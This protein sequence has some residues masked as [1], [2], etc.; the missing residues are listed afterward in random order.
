LS[1]LTR[2]AIAILVLFAVVYLYGLTRTGMLGPD[3]PR[4]AAIGLE[5]A[6]SGDWVTPRLWG[7]GWFEKPPLLYWMTAAA[8]DA[9]LGP[10]L[11]PR[12]PVALC[13]LAFLIFFYLAVRREFGPLEALYSTAILGTT[14]AWLTYNSVAVPDAPMS[15]LFCAALLLSLRWTRP[16]EPGGVGLPVCQPTRSDLVIAL[17]AG[18]LLG[19]AVL[20][21]S[22]VPLVLYAPIA[23][24]MRRRIRELLLIGA[25]CLAI[26][27]PWY[28]LCA[29]RNGA[30]FWDTLF[31][32]QQFMRLA[33]SSLQHVQPF[34]FYIPVLL[35]AIFPWIPLLLLVR[36]RIFHDRRLKL[37]LLWAGF[38]FLF[39]SVARNKLPGYILP[40][41]PVLSLFCGVGLAWAR[42]SRV[43]LFLAAL[44]I[45]ISPV[46]ADMLPGALSIGLS[47]TRLGTAPWSWIGVFLAIAIA[48]LLLG[49]LNR[50]TLALGL[51]A[52]S[53]LLAAMYVKIYTYPV[54]DRVASARAF[55]RA[56]AGWLA[57][58]CLQDV[59][60]ERAYGLAFYAG[61]EFPE[62]SEVN[63]PSA[64][65]LA[66]RSKIMKVGK[67]LILLD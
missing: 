10:D 8:A 16:I 15:A 1:S 55:Y 46:V 56:H 24:F 51:A 43:P 60:R 54:L 57:G 64:S 21:K 36:P 2:T 20:A 6:H 47:H 18:V 67:Q 22:L 61:H 28:L 25:A 7:S 3:E 65:T 27:L 63:S 13:G 30:P 50:R 32:R 19:L 45:A 12:L 39:F 49:F 52:A 62:C 23:W 31:V 34:W 35:G 58:A 41:V 38:T 4:Y 33:S 40:I 42:R 26:A 9:G 11:A 14:A 17:V 37:L 66:P 53:M 5:M 44:L 29:V 59:D 48:C